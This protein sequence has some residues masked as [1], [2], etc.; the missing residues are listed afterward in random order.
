MLPQVG[1]AIL[2]NHISP[3]QQVKQKLSNSKAFQSPSESFVGYQ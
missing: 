3:M 1:Q 2:D